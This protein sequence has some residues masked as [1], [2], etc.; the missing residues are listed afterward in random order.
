VP[1]LPPRPRL[2]A[3]LPSRTRTR[4]AA[5]TTHSTAHT[6]QR[7]D[8]VTTGVG[9]LLVTGY[10]VVVHQQS[11]W[12]ALNLAACATVLGMVRVS[13]VAGVLHASARAALPPCCLCCVLATPRSCCGAR[14]SC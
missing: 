14:R 13:D 7:Y 5:T 4:L 12:E 2:R 11:V 1:P 9:S 10:C 6:Q 8:P 3:L